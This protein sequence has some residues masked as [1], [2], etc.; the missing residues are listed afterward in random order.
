MNYVCDDPLLDARRAAQE[1]GLSLPGFW[2]AVQERRLPAP[3][4]PAARAPRWRQSEL[5]AA[6]EKTRALPSEQKAA[7]HG[8]VRARR[9]ANRR[10]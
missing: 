6:L 9:V 8:G 1:V 7:R 5:R 10:A 2:K 3:L 4:Y